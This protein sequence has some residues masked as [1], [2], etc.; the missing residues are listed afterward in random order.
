MKADNPAFSAVGRVY[1][2][3]A[4][5]YLSEAHV[6]VVGIGGVGSWV[7]EALAR[8]GIGHLTIIDPD[9]ISTSN[10]NRQIHADTS[11][12][13]LSKVEV[14]Q[15]RVALINPECQCSAIDDMLVTK[16]IEKY[17]D[18][19]FSYVVDAMDSIRFKASLIYFCKR[20]KIP[21]ITVGG[22]GGR[23]DPGK[24]Q[25]SDLTRTWND[26]LA[27]KVRQRLRSHHGWSTSVRKRFRVECVYSTEQPR[28]PTDD[29]GVS[30]SKPG[31][32]GVT[33]DC[34]NGFGSLVSVT[35]S[36]GFVTAA[37][38]MNKLVQSIE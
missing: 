24:I 32:R 1:G 13:D 15:K 25:I 2:R 8:S 17:I 35:A 7:V 20:N 30:Y 28:Y 3:L 23:S 12:V 14:M 37:R 26:P 18:N 10:I 9:D 31:V 36:F 21:V 29:G 16:N 5:E 22:A 6:C 33:L 19:G 38:V 4:Q 27:A 11:T 34:D